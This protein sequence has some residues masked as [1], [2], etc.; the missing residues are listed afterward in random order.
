VRAL[1][2]ILT[3]SCA[4][5]LAVA[6]FLADRQGADFTEAFARALSLSLIGVGLAAMFWQPAKRPGEGLGRLLIYLAF[7]LA[8]LGV[9]LA[10]AVFLSPGVR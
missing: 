10:L 4:V 5:G 1:A 3:I 8:A 6:W 9:V 7:W 2:A